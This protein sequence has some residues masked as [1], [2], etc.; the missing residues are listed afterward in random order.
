MTDAEYSPVATDSPTKLSVEEIVK[1]SHTARKW[2]VFPG[3]NKFCCD[4][5]IM[6]ARQAGIFYFTC[7]LI[8]GTCLLFFIF[9]CRYFVET[10]PS[11]GFVVPLAAGLLFIFVLS[12][13]FRTSFSDPGVIPRSTP[14]EAADLERQI[15]VPSSCQP[16]YRPPPRVREVIIKGQMVKLK[17][18]YTCKIFR[19]PRASHCSVCDNCVERFDH[20]CPWVGNC[21]GKRNYR[22]FYLFIMSLSVLCLFIFA[23]VV[24]HLV[25]RTQQTGQFLIALRDSPVS[26]VEA[27]ICFFSIW[28]LIGLGGY[29][30][31]L[32]A[33]GQSTNEDIKG[34]FSSKR[35]QDNFNPFSQGS[36]IGNCCEIICGPEYPSL[37]DRR[38]FVVPD[39]TPV[40]MSQP[41]DMYHNQSPKERNA[42]N[43]RHESYGSTVDSHAQVAAVKFSHEQPQ[44]NYSNQNDYVVPPSALSSENP[45]PNNRLPPIRGHEGTSAPAGIR[46]QLPGEDKASGLYSN[47][48]G[49]ITHV[50]A[51]K[52]VG[53]GDV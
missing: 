8:I 43:V 12:T 1:M 22:Y 40:Q 39:E 42:V 6:M 50:E 35:A 14:D 11:F 51:M 34:S 13:L 2:E 23:V 9:D 4:G 32:T 33:T 25:L 19:P 30:T 29:H 49:T 27:L 10:Y 18:C 47:S 44:K 20:H 36:C 16:N 38:G 46:E 45:M 28:S 53:P 5:R 48:D 15:E 26:I 24:T 52:D 17:F 3:R 31:Y 37:L 21:V 7:I 41:S